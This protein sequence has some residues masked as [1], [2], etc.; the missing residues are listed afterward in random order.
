M[1][2]VVSAAFAALG[3]SLLG[4]VDSGLIFRFSGGLFFSLEK[5]RLGGDLTAAFQY[6]KGTYKMEGDFLP[7]L[8]I[9]QG[10]EKG[11]QF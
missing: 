4:T 9:Y 1:W 6:I 7:K 8:P 11:Q 2:T 10:Q 3:E 5:R